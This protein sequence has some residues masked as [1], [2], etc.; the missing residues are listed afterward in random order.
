MGQLFILSFV[1]LLPK[2][3][4]EMIIKAKLVSRVSLAFNVSVC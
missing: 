1:N 2:D 4:G 3:A